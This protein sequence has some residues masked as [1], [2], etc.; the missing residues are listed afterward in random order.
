MTAISWC[1][2][3]PSTL[4]LPWFHICCTLLVRCPHYHCTGCDGRSLSQRD[5]CLT[6]SHYRACQAGRFHRSL[7]IIRLTSCGTFIIVAHTSGSLSSH[8]DRLQSRSHPLSS[9]MKVRVERHSAPCYADMFRC[10]NIHSLG[11]KL[12]DLLEVH[13]DPLINVMFLMETWHDSNSE[14]HLRNDGF[15]VVDRL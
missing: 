2:T 6:Y 3:Q 11:N 9:L 8:I 7:L 1:H 15:Q 12:D 4:E 14:S 13:H 5:D 10:L